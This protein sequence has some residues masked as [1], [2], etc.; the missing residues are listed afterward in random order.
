MLQ[1]C[2]EAR[3]Q[4]PILTVSAIGPTRLTQWS[5]VNA[6]SGDAGS[7]G[8]LQRHTA[9]YLCPLRS[10][11]SAVAFVICTD[12]Q[13]PAQIWTAE[14]PTNQSPWDG[15]KVRSVAHAASLVWSSHIKVPN[16]EAELPIPLRPTSC[17]SPFFF[18]NP[19]FCHI[20]HEERHHCPCPCRLVRLGD[21]DQLCEQLRRT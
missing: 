19:L 15:L 1:Q 16:I 7:R 13:I 6:K 2:K 4:A 12:L 21:P 20:R 3:Q 14:L 18:F 5:G 11:S 8:N 10:V 9:S 17:I